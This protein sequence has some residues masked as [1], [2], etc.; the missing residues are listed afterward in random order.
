MDEKL[1]KI[2]ATISSTQKYKRIDRETIHNAV[3]EASIRFKKEHEIDRK[4]RNT[5]H[6]LWGAYYHTAP[7]FIK[8]TDQFKKSITQGQDLQ[9]ALT[10]LLQLHSSTRE[11]IPILSQF[12]NDIF[13]I[14]GL[15]QSIVDHA[16]GLNPLTIPWMNLP[17]T[18]QYYAY[19]I[20]EKGIDFIKHTLDL[21][22]TNKLDV[23]PKQ[24]TLEHKNI[25]Q[26][27]KTPAEVAFFFKCF[28]CL[29]HLQKGIGIQALEQQQCKYA[30]VSFAIKSI[31]GYEKGM[32]EFYSI[33]FEKYIATKNW[34]YKKLTY[35]TEMVYIISKT[36]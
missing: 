35:D 21:V 30:V 11:R 9:I 7:N 28:T 13:T 3:V 16:C 20:D 8:A 29:D 32:K 26:S 12:Y 23:I 24:I 10:P 22:R 1:E 2:I 31:K 18:T 17:I 14:T 25:T 15:P 6:Q 36:L 4:A 19:D 27:S 33:N 5:L 34:E